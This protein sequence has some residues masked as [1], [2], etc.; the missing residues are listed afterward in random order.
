MR[1]GAAGM[2]IVIQLIKENVERANRQ[3]NPGR[4]RQQEQ[5]QRAAREE[6]IDNISADG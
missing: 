2:E 3:V 6:K 5:E 1:T 4:D